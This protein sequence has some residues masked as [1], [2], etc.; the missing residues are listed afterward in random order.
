MTVTVTMRS[1]QTVVVQAVTR[2][3]RR[4]RSKG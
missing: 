2:R 3:R 1:V 4:R